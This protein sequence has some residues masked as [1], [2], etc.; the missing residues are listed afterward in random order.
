MGD[1][2]YDELVRDYTQQITGHSDEANLI[3]SVPWSLGS[4]VD[5]ATLLRG[6]KFEAS[7][8]CELPDQ[9]KF[10]LIVPMSNT[11]PSAL[12]E[13]ILSVRCQ[14]WFIWELILIDEGSERRE[15]LPLAARWA[16]RDARIRFLTVDRPRG[17]VAAKNAALEAAEGEF[18]CLMEDRALLHPS[19]L[20]I[21]A[22]HLNATSEI[23]LIFS[24][25]AR[26]DEGTNQ[27][28]RF[29]RKPE[30][31]I[32]TILRK[33]YV[34][35]LTAI[36]SDLLR[37]V[38]VS[39]EVFR[40]GYDG[41]EDHDL[42]I[43]LALSGKVESKSL[44]FF[45]YYSRTP[46]GPHAL[47]EEADPDIRAMTL[48]LIEEHLPQLY[49]GA[50]WAIIP[51][52]PLAGNRYPG[53]H[54]R[55]LPG[56]PKPS[57]LVIVPF[58][59]QPRMTLRC[60]DS[61]ERQEHTL[62]VEVV[63]LD[64]R[65]KDPETKRVLEAW[66]DRPRRHRYLIVDHDGPFNYARINNQVFK[67]FGRD[68][69]LLLLLNND[70]EIFSADSLQ[71]MAMQVLADEKCGVVGMRLLYPDDGSV[72]H[73]G[74]K[75]WDDRRTICGVHAF[76]HSR[77]PEEYV[78]DE[79]ISFGVTFAI[80]MMRPATFERLGML[81]EIVFPNAFGDVAM[82]ARA[83]EAGL[84]NYYFGTLI[85]LHY[86]MKT[87]GLGHE[88]VEY[89]DVGERYSHVFS[90]WMLRSLSYVD[91]L[92]PSHSHATESTSTNVVVPAAFMTQ[93]VHPFRYRIADRIND[94]LKA[95]LGPAHPLV[96]SGIRH[97]W[98][99]LRGIRS[100]LV[101]QRPT[102]GRAWIMRS[103]RADSASRTPHRNHDAFT[104]QKCG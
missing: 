13:L 3:R 79:R 91:V 92:E 101:L 22:R 64:S 77:M 17:R 25:E 76:D 73:G 61:I 19:A 89:V 85:G 86:E 42:M 98:Y 1:L 21:F 58:K 94:T 35:H 66:A 71:T 14:S 8:F 4:R 47:A 49:P 52:S 65:S 51:P 80:A 28:R 102:N 33:N 54:L 62:D 45:L 84:K 99:V 74:V 81:E 39:G 87:R 95:V 60:L 29:I 27:I 72:Q 53:I 48:S 44:P 59:D 16:E 43:R 18:V 70:T 37:A 46:S 36:R 2:D 82:C 100:K 32:F 83:I 69:D 103:R 41:V 90:H 78:N 88:D 5:L 9:S 24:H 93:G 15:H 30:F 26:L 75:I 40:S 67:R 56:H 20:G 68:K 38:Q 11:P 34:G 7:R 6:L 12:N 63:M 55:S 10:S 23:N 104:N 50:R 31:D 96:R 57:L 97:S